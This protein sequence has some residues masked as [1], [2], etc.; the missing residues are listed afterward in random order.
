MGPNPM[1][2]ALTH[3]EVC[4]RLKAH[5]PERF[6]YA[7]QASKSSDYGDARNLGLITEAEYDAAKA[8]SGHLWNYC[9]D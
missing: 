9:G 1:P 4:R 3:G 8:S 7:G 2:D 6:K 5:N